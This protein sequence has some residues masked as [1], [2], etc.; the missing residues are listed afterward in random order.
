MVTVCGRANR[1]CMYPANSA[2]RPYVVDKSSTNL[3]GWGEGG[4]VTSVEWQITLCDP[5]DK[6]QPVVLRWISLRTI[7][8]FTFTFEK[9]LFWFSWLVYWLSC[10]RKSRCF[11]QWQYPSLCLF[12][13]S[14]VCL[15]P[16]ACTCRALA[17]LSS[18]R[19]VACNAAAAG[20]GGYCISQTSLSLAKCHK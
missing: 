5:I 14:F 6:W 18:S 10:C 2:F 7:L 13:C 9:I 4:A 20:G 11:L 19:G 17:W 1:L 15:L 16:E 8:S 3:L 12:M